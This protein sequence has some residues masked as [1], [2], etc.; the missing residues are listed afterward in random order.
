MERAAMSW[1]QDLLMTAFLLGA[2][3]LAIIW[4]QPF[5]S[6]VSWTLSALAVAAALGFLIAVPL[7]LVEARL[8]SA[9][10]D[11]SEPDPVSRHPLL[12]SC[13]AC[14]AAVSTQAAR[15]PG[16]GH[17]LQSTGAAGEAEG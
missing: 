2:P 9:R 7:R 17:P 6:W 11:R 15:C 5:A 4:I 8:A 16:C 10:Q 13:P 12:G 3:G 1:W 14:D